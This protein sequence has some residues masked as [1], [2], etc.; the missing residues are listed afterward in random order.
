MLQDKNREEEELLVVAPHVAVDHVEVVEVED[1]V[2]EAEVVAGVE[3]VAE[4]GVVPGGAGVED[5]NNKLQ[6]FNK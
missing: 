6:K 2:A 1:L 3:E 4:A 5:K